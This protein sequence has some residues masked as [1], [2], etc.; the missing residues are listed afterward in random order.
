[1][2]IASQ[3]AILV[4]ALSAVSLSAQGAQPS[5]DN[6]K[7]GPQTSQS[8]GAAA[9]H[10]SPALERKAPPAGKEKG[11]PQAHAEDSPGRGTPNKGNADHE[12]KGPHPEPAAGEAA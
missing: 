11:E 9:P 4:G 8:A 10:H 1:M 5:K 3:A 2:R 6:G 12:R 7:G